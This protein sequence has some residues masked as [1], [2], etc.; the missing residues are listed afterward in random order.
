MRPHDW[1]IGE[2]EQSER[3]VSTHVAAGAP[4]L[5]DQLDTQRHRDCDS[6]S[7]LGPASALTWLRLPISGT[8]GPAVERECIF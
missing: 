4:D 3:K 6:P 2:V 1:V 8:R 7:L 5:S